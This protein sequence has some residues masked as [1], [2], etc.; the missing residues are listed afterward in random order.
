[1]DGADGT[2]ER[3]IPLSSARRLVHDAAGPAIQCPMSPSPPTPLEHLW[4]APVIVWVV[5]AGEGLAAV[6][7][8]GTGPDQGRWVYFGLSSFVIQWVSLTTLG[9]LYLFRKG[10]TR[11]RP[12]YIAYFALFALVVVSGLVCAAGWLFL[13]DLWPMAK[14][15]W[16]SMFMRFTGIALIVGMLGLAAFLN[17]LRNRQLAVKAKQAELEALQA[18]IR[19]HFLFNTL[20]TAT[21][22]VHQRPQD[23]E[24]MLLDLADLF[25]AA[26]A[27]PREISLTEELA[28]TRR[29]LEIEGLRFG[30]RLQARW[31]LP[32]R[33]P[34]VRVPTLSIQPLVENAIRHGIEPSP[35]GGVV[36]IEVRASAQ[37][38][39][40]TIRN[41]IPER[42]ASGRGHQVG[43]SSVRARIHAL[44]Q[45]LGQLETRQEDGHYLAVIRLPHEAGKTESSVVPAETDQVSTR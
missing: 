9:A 44:T 21:A 6:L 36:G 19:P 41:P 24:R 42:P 3:M 31:D 5:L 7:A 37:G 35:S 45:G 27:G 38:I 33:V 39:A 34:D 2:A 15:G 23:T 8:L 30:E 17:H 25:R 26:L 20:N 22:L 10:L 13:R 40:I 43:Q 29:Y 4:Q 16:T 1:M 12:A 28:L 14:S 11:L 32:E 18:R